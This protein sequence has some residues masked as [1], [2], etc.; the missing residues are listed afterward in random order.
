MSRVV[1]LTDLHFGFKRQSAVFHDYFLKFYN[2]VFF[3][4]LEK[5]NITTVVDMG[6]T[7]D[8]RKTLDLTTIEWAKTNFY[9]R[10]ESMNIELHTLVG[11]HTTY[12]RN[13]NRINT[14]EL[15]LSQYSNIQTYSSP[16]VIEFDGLSVLMIPWINS[17][18]EKETLDLI[19][20][21]KAKVAMGHLELNGFYVNRG[22]SM[23]DG[24]DAD[25]FSKFKKVFTG[26]YHTRSDNGTVFYIG[27][28]YEM[29]FN[30]SGDSRGFV[31][32]DTETLKHAYVNNPYSLFDYVYYEDTAIES[33]NFEKY[34][35][36]IIK[37]IVRTKSDNV[38]FDQFI[39]NFYSIGVAD[40]KIIENYSQ[41]KEQE[42]DFQLEN[43]DTFSLIQRFVD[44][45]EVDLNKDKLKLILSEIH[46]EACELV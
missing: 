11:N 25:I 2:D 42:F 19:D 29:F 7:F 5:N 36:K 37:V 23:E 31:V 35:G 10:L 3:P 41:Q 45:S 4:F 26:H 15:L 43:E 22:T 34:S 17:E 14:P 8:N 28:P 13:T 1:I 38:L 24:R 9:D 30:D 18:N 16:T 40:L 46:K 12:Y 39:S 33:F 32:F 27:N 20:T 44:E 6:D 21:T